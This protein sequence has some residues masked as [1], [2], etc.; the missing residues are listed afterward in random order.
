MS[1]FKLPEHRSETRFHDKAP[2]FTESEAK[3]EAERCL[4]CVDAPC[5]KACP[6]SIDIPTFIKKIASGNVTGSA[7]TILE[8]NLLGYSCARVCPVEVLCAG[9]CVYNAT[10]R[11][12]IQ[13]GR[14]QR[15]ATETARA[16]GKRLLPTPKP[17][18]G[19]R[20]ALVGAGPASIA[21]AAALA[22][23]GHEATLFEKRHV[24]GGLNTYGIAPYKLLATDS[25]QEIEWLATLGVQFV[26]GR[27]LGTS[28]TGAELLEKYD[29]VFLGLGLGEDS[30]LP[31]PTPAGVWGATT[32][33]EAMKTGMLRVT[34]LGR[35]LVIGGGNTAIDAAREARGLGATEVVMAY[36]R[37]VAEMSG[38]VHELEGA[39]KEG[40]R[41]VENA[42]PAAFVDGGMSFKDS[43]NPSREFT[44]L[45]D[46]ILLAI[47]QAKLGALASQFPGVA[48]DAAGRIVVDEATGRTGHPRVY[49]GGDCVNGGKEVVNAV[50]EGQRAARALCTHFAGGGARET[51]KADSH[52]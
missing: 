27:E 38:Y 50:A 1:P 48:I 32:F 18:S 34:T 23:D 35:V 3:L 7:R 19:K 26:F 2:L 10:D 33:I 11:P 4:Y 51:R 28:I 52:G 16:S 17:K 43:S 30:R 31:L 25:L 13:I 21:C 45:A 36:R 37:T 41:L 6:T 20:V 29:A 5:I 15:Y 39:R 9:D 8:S 46:T 12:P 42:Q 44:I 49:S 47:G 14:L 40:V 24:P 22:L